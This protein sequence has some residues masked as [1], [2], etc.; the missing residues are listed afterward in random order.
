MPAFRR[1]RVFILVIAVLALTAI[2]LAAMLPYTRVRA[3]EPDPAQLEL[4]ARLFAENCAMCHGVDGQG[5]VGATLAKDWPSIRPDL[6][7]RAT[8]ENGISGSPMPA[9]SEAK[10]GPLT[11]DEIEALVVYILS[12]QTGGPRIIPPAPAFPPR[13]LITPLPDVEGDPNQGAVL[14][15]LNC[16]VCHGS[17]GEGRVGAT[18][19]K[20]FSSIR[21]DLTVKA[22][23]SNGVE[24]SPMP[25]WLQANGG[26]LSEAEINDLTAFVL[27]LKPAGEAPSAQPTPAP[28]PGPLAD[29]VAIL[30]TV[31]LMFVVLWVVLALQGQGRKP[32]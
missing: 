8:I 32:E 9:W 5:R 19:A 23:I 2:T 16:A 4:G 22:V 12:W 21:P 1:A 6:E 20:A 26:P 13:P 29:W 7:V 10:G 18:L 27:T 15:D 31:V 14:F 17:N 11:A 3:Q 30:V 28:L 24:G 25:A